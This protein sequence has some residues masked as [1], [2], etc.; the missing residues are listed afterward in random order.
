M[1]EIKTERLILRPPG[2][3]DAADLFA[4]FSNAK[5]MRYWSKP[6]FTDPAQTL[7]YIDAV[8]GA[9]P[10]K[11]AEFVVEFEGRVVGKAGFWRMPEVGYILHP[12]VWRRG[13]GEEALRA[14]MAYGFDTLKLSRITA[15][16]DPDNAGSLALLGKLGF[17]ETGRETNTLK[18]GDAWFDSVYLER[19]APRLAKKKARRRVPAGQSDKAFRQPWFGV[20]LFWQDHHVDDV[21]HTVG[22]FDVCGC[23]G[24][25][26]DHYAIVQINRQRAALNGW[27]FHVVDQIGGHHF[28]RYDVIGQDGNQLVFVFWQQ[29]GCD[30]AF[31]QGCKRVI[32]WGEYCERA[33]TFQCLDQAG[34]LSSG[35]QCTE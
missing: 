28:A 26:F 25:R 17:V 14:L 35:E 11:T 1:V 2:A 12:D 32:C 4:V 13:L 10:A 21:D 19:T 24:C 29:Q 3:E 30:C 34:G 16:V 5:A 18:I 23:D 6:M 8:R 20:R 7:E 27:C 9:D 15:D 22:R 31:W 33:F